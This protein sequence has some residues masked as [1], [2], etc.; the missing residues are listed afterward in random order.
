MGNAELDGLLTAMM[1]GAS[2]VS[3]ILMTWYIASLKHSKLTHGT[4]LAIITKKQHLLE[5]ATQ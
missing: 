4:Y 2:F 5:P 1:S 3:Y